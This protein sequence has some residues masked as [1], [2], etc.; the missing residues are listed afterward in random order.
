MLPIDV[1][2]DSLPK[3]LLSILLQDHP[4]GKNIFWASSNYG[5]AYSATLMPARWFTGCKG[6]DDFRH[7]MLD[8]KHLKLLYDYQR[9]DEVFPDTNNRGGL[10][11]SRW[12]RTMTQDKRWMTR[13]NEVV[14][15]IDANQRI[16]SKYAPEEKLLVLFMKRGRKLMNAREQKEPRLT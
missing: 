15:F 4:T 14:S 3:A 12:W 8:D 5:K 7:E 9:P 13:C 2:E 11:F 10:C 1:L 6:L 16:S